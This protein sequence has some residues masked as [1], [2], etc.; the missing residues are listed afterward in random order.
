METKIKLEPL[1]KRVIVEYYEEN[2]HRPTVTPGGILIPSETF[3]DT[4]LNREA[5]GIVE[6]GDKR[7]SYGIIREV[8][9]DCVTSIKVGDEVIFDLFQGM[10]LAMNISRLRVIP[11][12]AIIAMI[13]KE[14]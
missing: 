6:G 4:I 2:P 7:V 8:A 10:P 14:K 1:F 5:E 9:I 12:T 3:A 13:R 11:E